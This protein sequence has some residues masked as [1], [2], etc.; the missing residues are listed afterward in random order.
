MLFI[1]SFYILLMVHLKIVDVNFC[2]VKQ[3]SLIQKCKVPVPNCPQP[4]FL[5]LTKHN[6]EEV[7]EFNMTSRVGYG[8]QIDV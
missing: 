7:G 2:D 1:V 6:L 4:E 5:P 8:F 3:I